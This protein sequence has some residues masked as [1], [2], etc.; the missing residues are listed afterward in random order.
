VKIS[1]PDVNVWL[2]LTAEG[3]VHHKI[4][5][6]WFYTNSENSVAFCRVT[7]MGFLR[8]LTNSKALS[9]GVRTVIEAWSIQHALRADPRVTFAPE[10]DGFETS[11]EQLMNRPGVGTASWTDAYLAAFTKE[12]QYTLVTFDRGFE[13]WRDLQLSILAGAAVDSGR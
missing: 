8:L 13:R 4:A 2:A 10:P 11:W 6:S 5:R 12:H 1:L 3:H 9:R 7:Q